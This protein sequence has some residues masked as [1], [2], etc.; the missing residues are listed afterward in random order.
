MFGAVSKDMKNV[1]GKK[2]GNAD[3]WLPR[4]YKWQ[5]SYDQ[6]SC[7]GWEQEGIKQPTANT[8]AKAVH[9]LPLEGGPG[10]R[11]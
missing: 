1:Q 3:V 4:W 8:I 6:Q 11:V 9:A 7:E 5:R 10:C 2:N